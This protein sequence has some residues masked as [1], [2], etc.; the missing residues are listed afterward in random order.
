MR[1]T[2][3]QLAVQTSPAVTRHISLEEEIQANIEQTEAVAEVDKTSAEI[4]HAEDAAAVLED[5]A[6][7]VEK[8]EQPSPTES[9]LIQITGDALAAGTD[10]DPADLTPSMEDE[11]GA[12]KFGERAKD[13]IKRI[14][15]AIKAAFR[16]MWEWVKKFFTSTNSVI[17]AKAQR[18]NELRQKL[19]KVKFDKPVE[20]KLKH[21]KLVDKDMKVTEVTSRLKET[22]K[23]LQQFGDLIK[24]L[25]RG[26]IETNKQFQKIGSELAAGKKVKVPAPNSPVLGKS[27]GQ[28]KDVE[29]MIFEE[30]SFEL[31]YTGLRLLTYKPTGSIEMSTFDQLDAWIRGIGSEVMNKVELEE[32]Q[33]EGEHTITINSASE[34]QAGL[35]VADASLEELKTMSK[36]FTESLQKIEADLRSTEEAVGDLSFDKDSD[37]ARHL[38]A[39]AGVMQ[40]TGQSL[41]TS[42]MRVIK[43]VGEMESVYLALTAQ[44]LASAG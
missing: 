15:E 23:A 26:A 31:P 1:K 38:S 34:L 11:G 41:S 27:T 40:R 32:V 3:F 5:L 19:S 33:G 37:G 25:D 17:D 12:K 18:S 39:L 20:I 14:M 24:K 30:Y 10:A 6:T 21:S 44:A 16:R 28:K 36:E 4:A 8:I 43:A 13:T 22:F 29:G 9:A 2:L 42:S 35:A 7:V